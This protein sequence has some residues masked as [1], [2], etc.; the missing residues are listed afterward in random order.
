MSISLFRALLATW[1]ICLGGCATGPSTGALKL[2]SLKLSSFKPTSFDEYCHGLRGFK[3][4][5]VDHLLEA[6]GPEE[7]LGE[8]AGRVVDGDQAVHCAAASAFVLALKG[9]ESAAGMLQALLGEIV[10][11]VLTQRRG[12]RMARAMMLGWGWRVRRGADG[13][14]EA[15]GRLMRFSSHSAVVSLHPEAKVDPVVYIVRKAVAGLG[16]TAQPVAGERLR[17]LQ[18]SGE[19]SAELRRSKDRSSHHGYDDI[20]SSALRLFEN[21]RATKMR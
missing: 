20:A 21:S 5:E 12:R 8:A 3:Y 14:D 11:G 16:L 18:A 2:S 4:E 17:H 6:I 1:A 13:A 15:L 7:A 19:L 10:G 9:N